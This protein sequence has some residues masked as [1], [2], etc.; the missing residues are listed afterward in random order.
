LMRWQISL[1]SASIVCCASQAMPRS[2]ALV[3]TPPVS[4][5]TP[6]TGVVLRA[7]R[8]FRLIKNLC[9][10]SVLCRLNNSPIVFNAGTVLLNLRRRSTRGPAVKAKS[11]SLLPKRP[12]S[13]SRTP[14]HVACK[15]MNH[16]RTRNQGLVQSQHVPHAS[17]RK[18][19]SARGHQGTPEGGADR[20][21][22]S[23]VSL[24]SMIL[25]RS[26]ERGSEIDVNPDKANFLT[27]WAIAPRLVRG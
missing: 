16:R 10:L 25:T 11:Y 9:E 19:G 23:Y 4:R 1:A 14:G 6:A 20:D 13:N 22:Q 27:S 12:A 15:Q 5:I 17:W 24:Q 21:R 18:R 26:L 7:D 8:L 3:I 2:I